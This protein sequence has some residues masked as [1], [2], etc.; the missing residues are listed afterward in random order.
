MIT[1]ISSVLIWSDDYKKLAKWYKEIL[2][3]EQVEEITH[4]NDTGIG[5]QVGNVYLW[6]GQH[7]KV[8][9]KNKD[10]HRHMINFVVDSVSK[11]YKEL[12]KKGVKFFAKPFKAP[13]FDKYF[14]TFYDLDDNLV[15]LIGGK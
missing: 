9:G 7:S 3:L 1:N 10:I 12:Q 8:K 2:G 15:Q 4:P 14:V 11:S 5:F 13:T 6:I